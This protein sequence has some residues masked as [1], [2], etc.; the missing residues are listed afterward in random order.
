MWASQSFDP[1]HADPTSWQAE[2]GT[3]AHLG[4]EHT[5]RAWQA[6][7][8]MSSDSALIVRHWMAAQWSWLEAWETYR[9]GE[10]D[11]AP[12]DPITGARWIADI[13]DRWV[14]WALGHL[15]PDVGAWEIE[16]RYTKELYDGPECKITLTGVVDLVT[17]VEAIDWKTGKVDPMWQVD[18]YDHQTTVYQHLTGRPTS[19]V[20]IP[21]VWDDE[22]V[23]VRAPQRDE[24]HLAAL[25][26]ELKDV[27]RAADAGVWQRRPTGWWCSARW[28]GLH[29]RGECHGAHIQIHGR[30]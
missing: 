6:A 3:A 13:G 8:G 20:H 25:V 18:R 10:R 11:G 26:D 1:A 14:R 19:L 7:G 24:R 30:G 29:A 15:H 17:E 22:P 23:S 27:A 21:R 16:E 5:L 28:C 2:L 4:I 9:L 12:A